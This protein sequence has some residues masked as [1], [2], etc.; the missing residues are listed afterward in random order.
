MPG[1]RA[2]GLMFRVSGSGRYV[3]LKMIGEKNSRRGTG[4]TQSDVAI[5]VITF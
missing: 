4:G 2:C 1:L 3:N 5:V